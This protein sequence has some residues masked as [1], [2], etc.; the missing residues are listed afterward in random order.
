M[1]LACNGNNKL[2]VLELDLNNDFLEA[3]SKIKRL[4]GDE[5]HAV[6][7]KIAGESVIVSMMHFEFGQTLER[8]IIDTELLGKLIYV[9]QEVLRQ[10]AIDKIGLKIEDPHE[11]TCFVMKHCCVINS[12]Y[13]EDFYFQF[14]FL[15]INKP[16]NSLMF[17]IKHFFTETDMH[18]GH[19]IVPTNDIDSIMSWN[20]HNNK[21]WP[22]PGSYIENRKVKF[23]AVID[24]ITTDDIIKK[25][26]IRASKPINYFSDYS[27]EY[28]LPL[29]TTINESNLFYFT[30]TDGFTVIQSPK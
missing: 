16:L 9:Y 30:N 25:T 19:K 23:I 14:P 28:N 6:Y 18:I 11:L 27:N 15:L 8:N 10:I 5:Q 21:L 29:S 1:Y 20:F 4:L 17:N 12:I 26:T 3:S 24:D 22:L 7:Q 2:T 13:C